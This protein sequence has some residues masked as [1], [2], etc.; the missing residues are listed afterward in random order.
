MTNYEFHNECKQMAG[1]SYRKSYIPSP[2]NW[3][4]IDRKK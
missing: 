1:A 2:T 4:R 3:T